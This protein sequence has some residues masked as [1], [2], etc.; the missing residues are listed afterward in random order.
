M[1][2]GKQIYTEIRSSFLPPRTVELL[3]LTGFS[4]IVNYY[5]PVTLFKDIW[6]IGLIVF[7]LR[8]HDEPFWL[9]LMLILNDGFASFF[10]IRG[11]EISSL[12]VPDFEF[13]HLYVL[14]LAYK[15]VMRDKKIPIFYSNWLAIF[16]WFII[17]LIIRGLIDGLPQEYNIF[18]R[19]IRNI[20]PLLLFFLI[21]SILI[22]TEDYER[23]FSYV[24]LISVV[25]F[26]TQM[27]SILTGST[28]MVLLG[29]KEGV[30]V[31]DLSDREWRGLFNIGIN[32]M[33]FFGALFYLAAKKEVFPRAYLYAIL[34]MV[35]STVFFSATRGWIVGFGLVLILFFL[36]LQIVNF[37]RLLTFTILAAVALQLLLINPRIR[38]QFNNAIRRTMTLEAVLEGDLS[39]GGTASRATDQGPAVMKIWRESPLIGWG[40]SDTYYKHYNIHVGN[41]T[42]LLHSGIAGFILLTIF[43]IWFFFKLWRLSI[44]TRIRGEYS[45]ALL[46]FPI[47]F[48]GWFFIH[49][50]SGQQFGYTTGFIFAIPQSIW[51]AFGATLHRTIDNSLNATT[52]K[53]TPPSRNRYRRLRIAGS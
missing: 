15:V 45:S 3:A 5:V 42:I 17:I 53:H 28:P 19:T 31:D 27:I 26:I 18:L 30:I 48:V 36:F 14:A 39:A 12:G 16:Y 9:A 21:P 6:F 49:S 43:I 32:L 13:G 40:F 22:K 8:S 41:Q 50:T 23:L 47:F 7:Y 25:A 37:K 10:G 51:L 46:V 33:A 34:I 24:F 2:P 11:V 35:Y 20:F 52:S 38:T 29:L 4:I 44:A 1:A